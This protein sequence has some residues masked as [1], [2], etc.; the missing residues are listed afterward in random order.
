VKYPS[1]REKYICINIRPFVMDV[2]KELRKNFRIAIFTASV[3]AY[4]DTILDFLDP[5]GEIF[6][7]R[8]YREH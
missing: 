7:A 1:G 6:E 8:Y 4:A 2:L 5:E 3:R